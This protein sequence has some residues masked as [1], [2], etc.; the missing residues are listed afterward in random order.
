MPLESGSEDLA[1]FSG[2]LMNDSTFAL[3]CE[4]GGGDR[5]RRATS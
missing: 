5:S 4:L 2:D 1:G 3:C